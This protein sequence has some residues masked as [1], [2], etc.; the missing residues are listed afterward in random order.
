MTSLFVIRESY[1]KN[2]IQTFSDAIYC[3]S[4][5]ICKRFGFYLSLDIA[6]NPNVWI[7]FATLTPV[8]SFTW[9]FLSWPCRNVLA[10]KRCK[11]PWSCMAICTRMCMAMWPN[12][13]RTVLPL[14][15]LRQHGK[16]HKKAYNFGMWYTSGTLGQNKSLE[17]QFLQRFPGFLQ[18]FKLGKSKDVLKYICLSFVSF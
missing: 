5:I 11:P 17:P 10:M 2:K 3:I 6:E 15:C 18:L 13:F 4:C 16:M 8:C 9:A 12:S 7:S 14:I 1:T